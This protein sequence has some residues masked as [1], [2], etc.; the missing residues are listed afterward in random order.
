[1]PPV[2][3][4]NPGP[5]CT[6]RRADSHIIRSGSTLGSQTLSRDRLAECAKV[7]APPPVS[8]AI[9]HE[10]IT[11]PLGAS[12]AIGG[13][14][15]PPPLQACMSSLCGTHSPPS[16]RKPWRSRV[17]PCRIPRLCYPKKHEPGT[18]R[19]KIRDAVCS[20]KLPLIP[21]LEQS[22]TTN[23]ARTAPETG[24][25]ELSSHSQGSSCRPSHKQL[26]QGVTLQLRQAVSFPALPGPSLPRRETLT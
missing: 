6:H 10:D 7:R 20:P 13:F 22:P 2:Q 21:R 25:T 11:T 9:Q 1:M 19:C 23:K 4:S 24:Q 5:R 3:P 15:R 12:A 16:A 8:L 18:R 26:A 14:I 17:D